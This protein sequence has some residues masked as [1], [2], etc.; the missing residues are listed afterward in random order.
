MKRQGRCKGVR[1]QGDRIKKGGRARREICVEGRK[2]RNGRDERG[3]EE[4]KSGGKREM[5]MDR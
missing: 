5:G 1:K 2:E 3:S 4:R